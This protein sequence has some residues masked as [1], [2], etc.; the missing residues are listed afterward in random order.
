[1]ATPQ[2]T[3]IPDAVKWSI[4]LAYAVVL[5]IGGY[6]VS[7]EHRQTKTEE[8]LTTHVAEAKESKADIYGRLNRQD[9]NINK[10]LTGINTVQVDVA[11]IKGYMERTKSTKD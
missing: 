3:G 6:V 1:M 4:G 11:T 9:E 7:I 2:G 10:V 5:L 8:N